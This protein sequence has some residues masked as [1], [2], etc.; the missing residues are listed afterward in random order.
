MNYF[1]VNIDKAVLDWVNNLVQFYINVI[2]KDVREN[3]FEARYIQNY[4]KMET[5]FKY[6]FLLDFFIPEAISPD[7]RYFITFKLYKFQEIDEIYIHPILTLKEERIL[8]LK[9]IGF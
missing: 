6:T 8:K 2:T 7:G 1:D 5:F 3:H 4:N 9:E